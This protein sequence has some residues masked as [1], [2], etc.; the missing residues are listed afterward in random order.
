[1]VWA[2]TTLPSRATK[3]RGVLL[4]SVPF[5]SSTSLPKLSLLFVARRRSAER[6][7]T[8]GGATW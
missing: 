3:A 1:M 8:A 7:V 5:T 6:V 2:I 4:V